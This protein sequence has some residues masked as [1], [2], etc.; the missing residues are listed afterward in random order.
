MAS[1]PPIFSL[2]KLLDILPALKDGACRA[3]LVNPARHQLG[4]QFLGDLDRPEPSRLQV[5]GSLV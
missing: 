4:R 2:L 1:T 3:I 5:D